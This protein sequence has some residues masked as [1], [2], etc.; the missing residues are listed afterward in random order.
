MVVTTV[1]L[2]CKEGVA[3]TFVVEFE[4]LRFMEVISDAKLWLGAEVSSKETS[5]AHR[6]VH[7]AGNPWTRLHHLFVVAGLMRADNSGHFISVFTFWAIKVELILLLSAALLAFRRVEVVLPA[8]THSLFI[9]TLGTIEVEPLFTTFAVILINNHAIARA[10]WAIGT[11][12]LS[13]AWLQITILLFDRCVKHAFL[14]VKILV[15]H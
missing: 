4:A 12:H 9:L 7:V 8:T 14:L 10:H 13:L 3:T 2:E 6:R 11:R 1:I 5:I 15:L